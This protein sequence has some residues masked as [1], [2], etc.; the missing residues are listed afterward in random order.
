M[1]GLAEPRQHLRYFMQDIASL[2]LQ[3]IAKGYKTERIAEAVGRDLKPYVQSFVGADLRGHTDVIVKHVP[4]MSQAAVMTLLPEAG[5]RGLFGPY[6]NS[7]HELACRTELEALH[8]PEIDELFRW[9]TPMDELRKRVKTLYDAQFE[10]DKQGQVAMAAELAQKVAM[11]SQPPQPPQ[12]PTV[13][14][15]PAGQ[16]SGGEPPT[17]PNGEMLTPVNEQEMAQMALQAADESQAPPAPA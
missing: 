11:A 17:G 2:E 15:A 6:T 14:T 8:I 5:A 3:L 13:P 7:P 12:P 16:G 10:L 4:V 9:A 1:Q